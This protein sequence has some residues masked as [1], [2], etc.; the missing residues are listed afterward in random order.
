MSYRFVC[1]QCGQCCNRSP[2]V[3]LSEAAALADVFVFRLLFRLVRLPRASAGEAFFE[4]KR[5]L[6]DY[7]VRKRPVRTR[8]EGR[9]VDETE[10]LVIS[11]LTLDTGA[12]A[13]SAL[14]DGHCGVYDRRPFACRTVPLH[15]TGVEAAA[16]NDLAAFVATPGYACDTG[17]SAPVVV[18][19]GRI[20]DLP[21][22]QARA[23]AL[24]AAERDREWKQAIVQRT[25]SPGGLPLPSLQQV[26]TSAAHGAV[27][28]S[29]RAA[30]QVAVD[31][32]LMAAD[33]CRALVQAQL[34]T[35]ERELAFG[36]GSADARQTLAEMRSEYRHA[37]GM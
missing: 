32:G 36:H 7:A 15:Y 5:L 6:N 18:Q 21:T 20:V 16:A 12:G 29:M 34:A 26:E 4:K 13:C 9:S 25:K 14:E 22:R 3:E 19:D 33:A 28:T 24:A 17:E 31:A 10:Y 30:W 27:S 11:A 35:I 1:T 23:E 8:H 37:L 2:E